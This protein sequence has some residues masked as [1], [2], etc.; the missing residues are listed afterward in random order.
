MMEEKNLLMT[1]NKVMLGNKVP[2]ATCPGTNLMVHIDL[3]VLPR[4][5]SLT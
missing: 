1:T 4:M 2:Q 3:G 5:K